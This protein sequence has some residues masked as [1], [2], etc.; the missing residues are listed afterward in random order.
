[1]VAL[2]STP[3]VANWGFALVVDGIES[4]GALSY[5]QSYMD[6]IEVGVAEDVGEAVE[7]I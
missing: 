3:L 7:A 4:F 5:T 1:M 2:D 6:R